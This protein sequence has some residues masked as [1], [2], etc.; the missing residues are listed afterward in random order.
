MKLLTLLKVI[1]TWAWVLNIFP[2]FG[3]THMYKF[4]WVH[5]RMSMCICAYVHMEVNLGCDFFQKPFTLFFSLAW[6]SLSSLGVLT[7]ESQGPLCLQKHSPPCSG[8]LY[9]FWGL[10]WGSYTCMAC[11]L[12]ITLSP[13]PL[14]FCPPKG[15]FASPFGW[16]GYTG[17]YGEYY[18]LLM[19][20]QQESLSKRVAWVGTCCPK[21]RRMSAVCW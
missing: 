20:Q 13:Q 4:I 2:A 1:W 9:G 14:E 17:K 6:N 18:K 3:N 15:Q 11:S 12:L 5:M 19:N 21:T 8:F 7:R 10:N 16:S